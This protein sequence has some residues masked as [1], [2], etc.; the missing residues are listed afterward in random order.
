MLL[1]DHL[2]GTNAGVEMARRLRDRAQ[3]GPDKAELN[4]LCAEIEQNRE[5]LKELIDTL[6]EVGHPIK[7]AAVWVAGKTHRLG[8]ATA[9]TGDEQL[10]MLSH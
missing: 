2:G 4:R 8:V 6:G 9:I 1:N 5:Q 10:S 7:E 3:A